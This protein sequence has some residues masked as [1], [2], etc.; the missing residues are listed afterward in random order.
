MI[1]LHDFGFDISGTPHVPPPL[2][3]QT[4]LSDYGAFFLNSNLITLRDFWGGK[5]ITI[6][7]INL[8][9]T[10]LIGVILLISAILLYS[11]VSVVRENNK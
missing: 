5:M 9:G 2:T 1:T 3:R 10:I 11:L 7:E 8:A 4:T 6:H